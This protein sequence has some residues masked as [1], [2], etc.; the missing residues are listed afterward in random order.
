MKK[1]SLIILLVLFIFLLSPTSS[2]G[3]V[4]PSAGEQSSDSR[5]FVGGGLG[6][7]FGTQTSVYLAP[8]V[9]YAVL[10]D[11]HVG[12]GVS[13]EYISNRYYNPPLEP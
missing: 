13:Y 1:N 9:S 10:E 11:L 7:S 12:L 2:S 6:L 5:W 4:F 3:Q 8:E